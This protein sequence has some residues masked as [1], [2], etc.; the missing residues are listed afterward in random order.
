VSARTVQLGEVATIDRRAATEAEC[1]ELPFVG[2]EHIESNS[3]NFAAEFRRKP[4]SVLATKFRFGADHVLYGKLRPY[5]NKVALPNFEGVCTTEILPVLPK[6]GVLDR[7][8]LYGL[9]LSHEFVRWASLR[10][11]GANLPRLDPGTMEE[12]AFKLPDLPEQKRIAGLLDQADRLRRTRRYALELSDTFL[13]A[14]FNNLF[15]TN[16][17]NRIPLDDLA[18]RQR[19][20]F[21]NG[22]FGSDLLT[23]ELVATGTPVIYI[24]D[25]ASGRYERKSAVCVTPEK[26]AELST[27]NVLPGDLLFAKV[28]DPPG[29][30]AIY[31]EGFSTG[32]VTQDVIRLRLNTKLAHPEYIRALFNSPKGHQLLKPIIVQGTRERIGLTP[33]KEIAIPIP[34]LPQQHHFAALVAQHE[35]LRANQREALRQAEHLFQSLLNRAFSSRL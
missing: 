32:V 30:A 19:G 4:E 2:L 14:A 1:T 5:L 13:P 35:R 15:G 26:A 34:P 31:P 10:V 8:F 7:G 12:F 21:V 33:F 6:P 9:F 23:S 29:M 17:D 27:F 22:P 25:I 28:G 16:A 3:G 11:S 24:R 18:L 20:S